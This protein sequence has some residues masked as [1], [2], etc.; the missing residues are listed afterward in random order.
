MSEQR[1]PGLRSDFYRY[2]TSAG[3]LKRFLRGER[4]PPSLAR[5]AASNVIGVGCEPFAKTE[6]GVT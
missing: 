1:A 2:R 5:L 3:V 4:V 6:G